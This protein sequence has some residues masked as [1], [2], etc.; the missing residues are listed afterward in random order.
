M[1]YYPH[2][3]KHRDKVMELLVANEEFRERLNWSQHLI[4]YV[5][6]LFLLVLGLFPTLSHWDLVGQQ[7]NT[8]T[9]AI[10]VAQ[11]FALGVQSNCAGQAQQPAHLSQH[12]LFLLYHC[13][14]PLVND[15]FPLPVLSHKCYRQTCYYRV[16][17]AAAIWPL[18]KKAIEF[19]LSGSFSK[20]EKLCAS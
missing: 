7:R 2:P 3:K 4:L 1:Y 9:F 15:F 12:A 13:P 20:A 5:L 10:L 8:P 18:S 17:E 6:D 16:T 14:N 19:D 11:S